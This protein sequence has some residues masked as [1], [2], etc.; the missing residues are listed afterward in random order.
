MFAYFPALLLLSVDTGR[1]NRRS[2]YH[3]MNRLNRFFGRFLNLDNSIN[4]PLYFNNLLDRYFNFYYT[5]DDLLHFN[6]LFYRYFHHTVDNLLYLNN[7]LDF[8]NLLNRYLYNAINNL[9]Y[10]DNSLYWFFD[11]FL[12]YHFNLANSLDRPV[13]DFIYHYLYLYRHITSF[14]YNFLYV[15]RYLVDSFHRFLNNHILM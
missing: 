2:G 4:N 6:N 15:N 5:I 8:N 3:L 14:F 7:L 1:T 11:Y 12:G 10:F 13:N 9:L